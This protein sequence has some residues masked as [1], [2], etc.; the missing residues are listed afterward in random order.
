[1]QQ[2]DAVRQ[3]EHQRVTAGERRDEYVWGTG[4]ECVGEAA[5]KRRRAMGGVQVR[6]VRKEYIRPGCGEPQVEYELGGATE[7]L[8]KYGPHEIKVVCTRR[9]EQAHGVVLGELERPVGGS[10]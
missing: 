5:Q 7:Q 8:S 9:G 2:Q 6:C 3:M 4:K 10:P 1:M